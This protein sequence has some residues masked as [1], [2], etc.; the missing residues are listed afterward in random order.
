MLRERDAYSKVSDDLIAVVPSTE[1][2]KVGP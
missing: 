1:R 2:M